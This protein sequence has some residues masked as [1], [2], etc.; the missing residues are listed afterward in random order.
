MSGD[1]YIPVEHLDSWQQPV[2]SELIPNASKIRVK[3]TLLEQ[4]SCN[5]GKGTVTFRIAGVFPQLPPDPL[6][7]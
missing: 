5:D 6:K 7:E 3:D 1:Q 4:I 2:P